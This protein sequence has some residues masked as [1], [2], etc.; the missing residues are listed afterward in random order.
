MKKYYIKRAITLYADNGYIYSLYICKNWYLVMT[1]NKD[2]KVNS[3]SFG[4]T[5]LDRHNEKT[6]CI[7]EINNTL[8]KIMK[9]NEYKDFENY[10]ISMIIKVEKIKDKSLYIKYIL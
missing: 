6:K 3:V 10:Y 2:N 4:Q 1:K 9:N 5:S 8:Y 7:I